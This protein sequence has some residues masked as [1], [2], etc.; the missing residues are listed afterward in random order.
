MGKEDNPVS[1]GKKRDVKEMCSALGI[2]VRKRNV[3]YRIARIVFTPD[4][5]LCLNSQTILLPSCHK[6]K[7][8]TALNWHGEPTFPCTSL[9]HACAYRDVCERFSKRNVRG[10]RSLAHAALAFLS[11]CCRK[12]FIVITWNW[13]SFFTARPSWR[14]CRKNT[15]T[16]NSMCV[17]Y[18]KV[19]YPW[20]TELFE[21]VIIVYS[22]YRTVKMWKHGK[23]S[24][25]NCTKHWKKLMNKWR[26]PLRWGVWV[27]WIQGALRSARFLHI[28]FS[29][30]VW[31]IGTRN[32]WVGMQI[33][34]AKGGKLGAQVGTC[35]QDIA[36]VRRE[37]ATERAGP[38]KDRNGNGCQATGDE[39]LRRY[40]KW[41]SKTH[42]AITKKAKPK[43]LEAETVSSGGKKCYAR[44]HISKKIYDWCCFRHQQIAVATHGPR[45]KECCT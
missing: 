28:I 38:R 1:T 36:A 35:K 27:Y 11:D 3:Y 9:N 10:K 23:A 12:Q 29:I 20:Y 42:C 34:M 31:R 21:C 26:Q 37:E 4:L 19:A 39:S 8:V 43:Q 45:Q 40:L 7:Q 24:F 41:Y 44:N 25:P 33:W 15:K 16:Q 5:L 14:I 30:E 2:Q 32:K 22:W 17:V 13:N 18:A 6:K